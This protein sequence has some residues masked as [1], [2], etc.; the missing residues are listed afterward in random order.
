MIDFIFAER[1]IIYGPQ[2]RVLMTH[3]AS[4]VPMAFILPFWRTHLL[5]LLV[6]LRTTLRR[7]LSMHSQMAC[8]SHWHLHLLSA[9]RARTL[10]I[11]AHFPYHFSDEHL[12]LP[13]VLHHKLTR[14]RLDV[15]STFDW[16]P[17]ARIVV[18][19]GALRHI[20]N[21][22][23]NSNWLRD[24]GFGVLGFWGFVVVNFFYLI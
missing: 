20:L 5:L 8:S 6:L 15:G 7:P 12:L 14:T 17:C 19:R 9:L 2:S 18:V 21:S 1:V 4:Q 3:L 13:C 11:I 10:L 24:R 16:V 22:N 23:L